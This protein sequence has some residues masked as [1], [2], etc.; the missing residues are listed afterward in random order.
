MIIKIS[1]CLDKC[2]RSTFRYK[3][4]SSNWKPFINDEKW[5]LFEKFFSFLRYLNFCPEIFWLCR[6]A[7]K[8]DFKINNVTNWDRNHYNSHI[9][10]SLRE[11]CP[12]SKFFWS[13]FFRIWT[14][15]GVS[16]LIQFKCGKI[17]TRKTPNADT[18]PAVNISRS[19][20]NQATKFGLLI[21]YGMTNIFLEKSKTKLGGE[22]SP[23]PFSKKSKLSV[24]LE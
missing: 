2:E 7:A 4:F 14:E 10:Q 11:K 9:T 13:V 6:K 5:F 24:S 22:T 19:K 15:Y 12:Y 21:E 18:F 16:L 1:Y 17:Q 20:G 3:R 8:F 23:R